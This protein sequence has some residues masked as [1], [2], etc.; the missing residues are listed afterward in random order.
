MGKLLRV[1]KTPHSVA[2]NDA[3]RAKSFRGLEI[4]AIAKRRTSPVLWYQSK[5]FLPFSPV[6]LPLLHR[7]FGIVRHYGFKHGIRQAEVVAGG[8]D[9]ALLR[10]LSIQIARDGMWRPDSLNQFVVVVDFFFDVLLLVVRIAPRI[11]DFDR[12]VSVL[13]ERNRDRVVGAVEDGD[14][15]GWLAVD[16]GETVVKQRHIGITHPFTEYPFE[17]MRAAANVILQVERLD[18]SGAFVGPLV[19]F[20]G[21]KYLDDIELIFDLNVAD[22]SFDKEN[23]FGVDDFET[24]LIG[25]FDVVVVKNSGA[26]G[27]AVI[28][29]IV[30]SFF[31]AILIG[32]VSVSAEGFDGLIE[33]GAGLAGILGVINIDGCGWRCGSR[34]A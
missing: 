11:A 10:G 21:V 22:R 4:F 9:K 15:F 13:V 12:I 2:R 31:F 3:S 29:R 30:A 17:R 27:T 16:D 14:A 34:R 20:I 32:K 1:A 5:V 24:G 25:I 7:R 26:V 19:S 6:F 23:V 8:G 18:G 28:K 33:N